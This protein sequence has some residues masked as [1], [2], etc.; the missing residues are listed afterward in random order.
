MQKPLQVPALPRM[1]CPSGLLS[2]GAAF[3]RPFPNGP[4]GAERLPERGSD[5]GSSW[6]HHLLATESANIAGHW[7]MGYFGSGSSGDAPLA[8]TKDSSMEEAVEGTSSE[9]L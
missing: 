9:G 8:G 5:T 2:G 1:Q 6:A 7:K 3:R 4:Q